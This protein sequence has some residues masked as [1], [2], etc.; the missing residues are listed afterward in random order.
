MA[1]GTLGFI[2]EIAGGE[3][4]NLPANLFPVYNGNVNGGRV[5]ISFEC[6]RRFQGGPRTGCLT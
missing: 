6:I 1:G 5:S 2:A 3:K 4:L